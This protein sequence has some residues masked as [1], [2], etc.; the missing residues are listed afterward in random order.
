MRADELTLSVDGRIWSGWKSVSVTRSV[1]AVA[2]SF[3]ISLLDRWSEE[4]SSL[5]LTVDMD[6]VVEIGGD[7]V[8]TGAIDEVGAEI[9]AQGRAFTVSGRDRTAELVD[10]SAVHDPGEWS[11]L[12]LPDLASRLAELFGVRVLNLAPRGE[13]FSVCKIQPGE[14]AYEVLERHCRLRGVLPTSDTSG[15]LVLALPGAA[16]CDEALVEGENVLSASA[17]FSRKDRFSDYFVRGQAQGTDESY[18]ANVAHVKGAAQDHGL[19]RWRPLLLTAEGQTTSRSARERARWE[20]VVR[21]A[22]AARCTVTVQGWRQRAGRGE[23]WPVNA[24]LPVRIPSVRIEGEMLITQVRYSLSGSGSVTE[25]EL[26]RPD[27][28]AR[29]EDFREVVAS[30]ANSADPTPA[31]VAPIDYGPEVYGR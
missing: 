28:F 19:R 11:G 10:C 5:P 23:L 14:T 25:L 18:G 8:I 31:A 2:G 22:R 24:V 16:S 9:S 3:S 4:M 6:C 15:N 12:D 29:E 21:A 17:R 1:E 7:P 13:K 20:A 26:A 30:L 27:A